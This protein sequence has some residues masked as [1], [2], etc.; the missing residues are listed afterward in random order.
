MTATPADLVI[1]GINAGIRL[2]GN[3]RQ[4]YVTNLKRRELTLP[5]VPFPKERNLQ[6][7]LTYFHKNDKGKQQLADSPRLKQL[8][9]KAKTN[10]HTPEEEKEIW[11]FYALAEEQKDTGA[12]AAD[13]DAFLGIRQWSKEQDSKPTIL[14]AVAGSL[15]EAGIGYFTTVPGAINPGSRNADALKGFLSGLQQVSF[16][17]RVTNRRIEELAP[18]LMMT[19][20]ETLANVPA[21]VTSDPKTGQ[22]VEAVTKGVLADMQGRFNKMGQN[23]AGEEELAGFGKM[24]FTSLVSNSVETTLANAEDLLQTRPGAQTSLVQ[25]LGSAFMQLAFNENGTATSF[26]NL[27]TVQAV[28][29]MVKASL[30][31]VSEHPEILGKSAFV[32]QAVSQ[33]AGDLM[34][35]PNLM[36]PSIAPEVVRLVL[37]KASLNLELLNNTGGGHPKTLLFSFTSELLR[38][39]AT[40][41]ANKPWKPVLGKTQLL[42]LTEFMVGEAAANPQWLLGKLE[43]KPLLLSLT[44]NVFATLDRQ[45][46][47]RLSSGTA[48]AMLQTIVTTSGSHPQFLQKV[49]GEHKILAAQAVSGLLDLVYLNDNTRLAL[50]REESLALLSTTFFEKMSE[51]G[52]SQQQIDATLQNL[53]TEFKSLSSN[54]QFSLEKAI[55]SVKAV[56]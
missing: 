45:E 56:A 4:A 7:I 47:P 29:T 44:E 21:V 49:N 55:A 36:Q 32:Q 13:L 42:G 34:K 17:E 26:K 12:G 43:G 15:V 50:A 19:T 41:E 48:V 46:Q 23:A 51:K 40:K 52:V 38:V 14:S 18:A 54:G 9:D 31:T 25:D 3:I 24:L 8:F 39:V 5:L 11:Q 33:F 1:F 35:M 53:A 10:R 37:E 30:K 6:T 20:L 28:D 27:L 22:L 2:A 16:A